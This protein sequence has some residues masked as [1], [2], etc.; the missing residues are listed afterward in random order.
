[1]RAQKLSIACASASVNSTP[2]RYWGSFTGG[3]GSSNLAQAILGWPASQL[4]TAS[5][6]TFL[7]VPSANLIPAFLQEGARRFIFE[8]RECGGHVMSRNP[9]D[10]AQMSIRLGA[11]DSDPGVRPVYR[12]FVAYAAGWEPLPDDGLRRYPESGRAAEAARD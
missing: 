9:D 10:H 8:G 7:H 1:M 5:V 6:P 4:E 11:F 3:L 12:Q 2:A